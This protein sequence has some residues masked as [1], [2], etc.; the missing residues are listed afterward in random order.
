MNETETVMAQDIESDIPHIRTR[1]ILD[2]SSRGL[3]VS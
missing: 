2:N 1:Q 3:Y